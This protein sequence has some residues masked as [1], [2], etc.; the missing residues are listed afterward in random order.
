MVKSFSQE[1]IHELTNIN[2]V[3][4]LQSS[5]SKNTVETQALAYQLRME[6]FLS[7]E[8]GEGN[9]FWASQEEMEKNADSAFEELMNAYQ[10]FRKGGDLDFLS[11]SPS[12][13]DGSESGP[14][15]EARQ[16]KSSKKAR[17]RGRRTKK[18]LQ[19]SAS[20][21]KGSK[22]TLSTTGEKLKT[23]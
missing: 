20:S 6:L 14:S 16:T 21:S 9:S 12:L 3:L 15:E 13:T 17:P 4:G 10:L 5:L 8:D 7:A 11:V 18:P 2:A 19:K 22:R 23:S 1:E